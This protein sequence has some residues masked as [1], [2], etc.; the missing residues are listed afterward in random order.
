M[1]EKIRKTGIDI[2]SDVPW[3]TH[4]C[5]FYHT[6]R[7]LI[8][9]LVPY[10]KAG[11]ENNEFCMWVTSEPLEV[12]DAKSSL[13]SVVKDLDDYIKKGQIEVLDYSQW[14]TKSGV[15][16]A[17]RV[18]QGWVEKEDQ[19]LK[20][21]FDGLRLTGNTFWLEKKDWRSFIDYEEEINK[22]IGKYRMIAI[23]TYSLDKC[24]APEVID[25]VSSHQFAL[26]KRKGKWVLI[27]SSEQKRVEE[28]LQR[29]EKELVIR[30]QIANIFLTIPDDE[31]YGEA[32]RVILEAMESKYGVFGYV[33]EH[34]ALVCPSMTKD[35]WDKCRVPDKDI[36]FPRE[37]W[38]GIWGRALTEKKTFYSN[39][40]LRVPK[41]H[42]SVHSAIAT[43]IIY[44]DE[45][46]GYFTIA[47]KETDYNEKDRELLETIADRIA[48]ILKARLQ[49]DRQERG[50]KRAE[51]AL[52]KAHRELERRVE[53]RTTKLLEASD[54]LRHEIEERK[55]AEEALRES[56]ERLRFFSS[57]LLAAKEGERKRVA[58][59]LH[60]GIG[61]SLT[62]IKYSVEH[63]LEQMG[64]SKGTPGV[65]SLEAT[66]PLIQEVI[67]EVRRIEIDLRPPSLDDLGILATISWFCREFQTIYSGIGIEKQ[68]SIQEDEVPD[69][70]KTVI[71]RVL[72]E[73]LNNVAKHSKAELVRLCLRKTGDTLELEIKDNGL[74]FNVKDVLSVEDS[75]RGFG[76]ASMR[77]RTELSGGSFAIES[78][79]E[80]GTIVRASWLRE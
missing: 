17:D 21:G 52:L 8:D 5:L 45:A 48:P 80:A 18:L 73:A 50:R 69:H 77:E 10:F 32:V 71:Y 66:I 20:R 44:R 40:N 38:G 41:G 35:I 49:R 15:F 26:I 72:Q 54:R 63:T 30:N 79:R 42:I 61:Q 56:G 4:F 64:K 78:I 19:A 7:D 6:K 28:A 68:I 27:E 39:K 58:R 53:E 67:E 16:E 9:I 34:G 33:D 37:K 62:A 51:A 1:V 25:V 11:L 74:G 3:S 65:K 60:D 43:P 12:E 36:V 13:K 76:L 24:G 75:K 47:N 46:I 59:E 31:M 2:I 22:T 29:S 57:Q 23:C 14:Y 55:R 70:L